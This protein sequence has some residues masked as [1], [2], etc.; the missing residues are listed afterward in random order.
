MNVFYLSF[1]K[2]KYCREERGGKVIIDPGTHLIMKNGK[3]V[4][5]EGK[6]HIGADGYGID[7]RIDR[8]RIYI[9]NGELTSWCSTDIKKG[10]IIVIND[11]WLSIGCNTNI[12][13]NTEIYCSNRI[14][15]GNRCLVSRGVVIRD[16]DA[17]QYAYD[18]KEP[19]YR[20]AEVII[21]DDVWIGQNS[22]I[23]PGTHIGYG[24]VIG[25]GA[26]VTKDVPPACLVAGVPAS[27]KK[28]DVKWR[29]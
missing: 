19:E 20:T 9:K 4:A 16:T 24:A 14:S 18:G 8:C 6:L 21:D 13:T 11:G 10:A 3:I 12:N 27:I 25:A 2:V 7:P 5:D 29:V 15:I 28:V 22:M 17:H 23:M 1:C 26:I